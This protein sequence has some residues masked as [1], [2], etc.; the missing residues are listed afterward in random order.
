MSQNAVAIKAQSSAT[1]RLEVFV[2]KWREEGQASESPFGPAAKVTSNH[3]WEWLPGEKFL[4]HRIEGRLGENEMACIEIIG[5]DTSSQ[6]FSVHSFY[7]DGS[8]NI[9]QLGGSQDGWTLTGDW[10]KDNETTR[11][12]CA[13][14]FADSGNTMTVKWEYSSGGSP[15]GVF[16]DT[17]LKRN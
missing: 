17:Q 12:R 2:G 7:N 5:P 9:W 13:I 15:W 10:K 6:N 4:I 11:V 1:K 8:Q 16:W 14:G 3:T